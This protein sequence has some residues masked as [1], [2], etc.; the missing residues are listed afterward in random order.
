MKNGTKNGALPKA[1]IGS[2]LLL[3]DYDNL[4]LSL[5]NS[6]PSPHLMRIE[7][8][9]TKMMVW[10]R[11]NLGLLFGAEEVDRGIKD[12]RGFLFSP[13]HITSARQ[14]LC[15]ELGLQIM[16]CPKRKQAERGKTIEVDTVDESLLWFGKNMIQH[17]AIT[18]LCLVS[19]DHHFI[20]LLL[21]AGT[22]GIKRVIV[23]PAIGSLSAEI[24]EYADRDPKTQKR[25]ILR[26]DEL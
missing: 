26:L 14:T 23:S 3:I 25:L 11:E 24:T 2:V 12:G 4:V 20:P 13:E 5:H 8:R 21:E 19:G 10:I 6:Y 9:L 22:R 15:N 18:T 16:V 17:P 7:Y 1:I